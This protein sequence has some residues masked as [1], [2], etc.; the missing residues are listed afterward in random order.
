[1]FGLCFRKCRLCSLYRLSE[2]HCLVEEEEVVFK[3]KNEKHTYGRCKMTESVKICAPHNS[4][5]LRE[6]KCPAV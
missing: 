6:A 5:E 4:I 3:K 2:I 1:M